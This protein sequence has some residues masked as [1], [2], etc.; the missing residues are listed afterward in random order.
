MPNETVDGSAV[1]VAAT[2][3]PALSS[4]AIHWSRRPDRRNRPSPTALM[5]AHEQRFD[6]RAPQVF[7]RMRLFDQRGGARCDRRGK[8]LYRPRPVT[9]R[10]VVGSP[11]KQL[12]GIVALSRHTCR[13]ERAEKVV[14]V[15]RKVE[16]AAPWPRDRFSRRRAWDSVDEKTASMLAV[17]GGLRLMWHGSTWRAHGFR[18]GAVDGDGL[19]WIRVDV[20]R[21]CPARRHSI[22]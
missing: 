8:N 5:I 9:V 1:M 15:R 16:I 7:P 12:I 11:R 4:P 21:Q 10:T 14:R 6:L 19:A 13:K 2:A 18:T 20:A 22:S 3:E 17:T